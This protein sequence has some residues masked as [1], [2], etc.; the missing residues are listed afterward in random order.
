MNDNTQR[1]IAKL[2]SR[3]G[4]AEH[5]KYSDEDRNEIAS[6]LIRRYADHLD[7]LGMVMTAVRENCQIYYG[8]PELAKIVEAINK[9][10][11]DYGEK[12]QLKEPRPPSIS[13][14]ALAQQREETLVDLKREA[15]KIGIDTRAEHWVAKYAMKKIETDR[16]TK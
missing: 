16:G 9:F 3:Y 12:I 8:L 13:K 7:T 6:F 4:T 1:F 2:E 14:E 11:K 10:Q 15:E 5:L